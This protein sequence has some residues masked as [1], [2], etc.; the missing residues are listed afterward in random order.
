MRLECTAL[1]WVSEFS[2][3]LH[4]VADVH[5][6]SSGLIADVPQNNF[7]VRVEQ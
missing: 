6:K 2:D 7:A 3:S 1:L 4:S 5:V